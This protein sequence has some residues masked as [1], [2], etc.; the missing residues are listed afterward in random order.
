MH[1]GVCYL[2]GDSPDFSNCFRARSPGSLPFYFY[3]VEDNI[4]APDNSPDKNVALDARREFESNFVVKSSVSDD[5]V[6]LG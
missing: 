4:V 6:G 1:G 5:S 3:A 2:K